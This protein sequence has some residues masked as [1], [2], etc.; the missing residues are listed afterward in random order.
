M[1]VLLDQAA[2]ALVY[3]L[4]DSHRL[5]LNLALHLLLL[6]NQG[7]KDLSVQV[8][9]NHLAD[10]QVDQHQAARLHSFQAEVNHLAV[11]QVDQ[12]QV[13]NLHSVPSLLREVKVLEVQMVRTVELEVSVE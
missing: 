5:V 7:H 12:H 8:E 9:V 1:E 13:V 3:Q 4:L 10:S 2:Q 6:H 11:S